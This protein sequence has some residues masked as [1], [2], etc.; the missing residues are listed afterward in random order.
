MTCQKTL[1]HTFLLLVSKI[2]ESFQCILNENKFLD[3][4]KLSDIVPVFKKFDLTYKTNIR[5]V[6]L[7]TSSKVF[8]KTFYDQHNTL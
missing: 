8:E 7:L 6:G 2:V 1:L 3:T 5:P 4:P